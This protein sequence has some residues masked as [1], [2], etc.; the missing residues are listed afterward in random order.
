M[1]TL[2]ISGGLTGIGK[3]IVDIFLK[4]NY[5]VISISRKSNLTLKHKFFQHFQLNISDYSKCKIFIEYLK[6]ENI[7]IDV[8]INNAGITNDSFLHKMSKETWDSVINVNLNGTFYL[9]QLLSNQLIEREHA[10]IINISSIVASYG[11]IGQ[12]NY[13]AS[14]AAIEGLTKVWAKEFALKNNNIRVNCISPGFIH[15]EMIRKVPNDILKSITDKVTL[16][17]LGKPEEVA[18]LALFLASDDASYITGQIIHVNG[19]LVL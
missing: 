12:S 13:V 9:T 2:L 8:L 1:K 5:K 19:G 11:N 7:I 18:K 10:S 6:K 16:K 4:N 17:R 14:K 15:T 3:S